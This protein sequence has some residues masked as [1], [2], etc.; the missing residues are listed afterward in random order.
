MG[1]RLAA[2]FTDEDPREAALTYQ[3]DFGTYGVE[4]GRLRGTTSYRGRASGGIAVL[5]TDAFLTRRVDSS[6]AV[7]SVPGYEGVKIYRDNQ[8]VARTN[9]Q[10]MAL[11]SRLRPYEVNSVRIDAGDLPMDAT[12][13]ALH[14]EAIPYLRSGLRLD[15][16]VRRSGGGLLSIVLDDGEPIPAGAVVTVE[17]QGEEF[18]VGLRGEVYVTGLETTSRL[19][20]SWN[21]RACTF[22]VS[23]PDSEDPL[24][25]LGTVR[26]SGVQR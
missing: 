10:G 14:L 22:D 17:G 20:A 23:F 4:V 6:F 1:Y 24:P 7:V 2:G 9:R 8:Q 11:I 26:C 3:N 18:P 19:R 25:D 13:G 15:F 12:I 5:G 16:P 21:Q